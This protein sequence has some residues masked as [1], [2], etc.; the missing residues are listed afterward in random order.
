MVIATSRRD[1]PSLANTSYPVCYEFGL[2]IPLH[3]PTGT[4]ASGSYLLPTE[5]FQLLR[6]SV[7]VACMSIRWTLEARK[8]TRSRCPAIFCTMGLKGIVHLV[9]IPSSIDTY[10]V[11]I[12]N[13]LKIIITYALYAIC[14]PLLSIIECCFAMPTPENG[15]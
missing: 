15:C 5:M 12:I 8:A 10:C 7:H 9:H 2:V 4:S 13:I 14:V 3:H 1:L 11:I 6:S